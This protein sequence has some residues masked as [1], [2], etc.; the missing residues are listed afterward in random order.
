MNLITDRNQ[1]DVERAIELNNL[2]FDNWTVS[3][4]TEFLSGLKGAYNASDLNRVESAVSYVFERFVENGYDYP[5]PV[6]KKT[7]QISEFMNSTDT[8]R[9]LKNIRELRERLTVPE[10][11]PE[12]PADMENFTYDKANDIER[13]LEILDECIDWIEQSRF[14]SGEL[15]GGEI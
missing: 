3:E 7:W 10:Y 6:V 4:V 5:V 11:T 1:D 14:Y 9:Y 13:I 15:Y 8:A 12:V 2:G